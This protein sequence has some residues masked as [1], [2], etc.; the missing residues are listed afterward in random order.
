MP[1]YGNQHSREHSNTPRAIVAL[2]AITNTADQHRSQHAN[3]HCQ[4]VD[5]KIAH[6]RVP[7]WYEQLRNFYR[8]GEGHHD[9]EQIVRFF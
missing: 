8:S 2:G 5:N 9:C 3:A 1:I 4:R 7:A 6:T